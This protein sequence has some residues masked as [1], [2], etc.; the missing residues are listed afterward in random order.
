MQNESGI[1][2][3]AGLLMLPVAAKTPVA[4]S[5]NSALASTSPSLPNMALAINTLPFR[6]RV[7]V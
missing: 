6:R 3:D 1:L 2:R 5:Y 7:T 4:G